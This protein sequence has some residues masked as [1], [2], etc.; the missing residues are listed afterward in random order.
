MPLLR[1]G[2]FRAVEDENDDDQEGRDE[3]KC[4]HLDHGADADRRVMM[5]AAA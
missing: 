2:L 1:L 5:H 4:D 3:G